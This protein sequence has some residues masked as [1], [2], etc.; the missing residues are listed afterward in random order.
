[1]VQQVKRHGSG[2]ETRAMSDKEI[3]R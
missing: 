1:V 3:G 2:S